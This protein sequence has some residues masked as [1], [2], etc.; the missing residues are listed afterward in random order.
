M[1]NVFIDLGYIKLSREL[2]KNLSMKILV[3][4]IE[5][6]IRHVIGEVISKY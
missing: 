5:Y 4:I 2:H 3:F 1:T 6:S